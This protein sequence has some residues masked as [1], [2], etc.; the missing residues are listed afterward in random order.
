MHVGYS[1]HTFI[2]PKINFQFLNKIKLS[3]QR[4]HT[5]NIHVTFLSIFYLFSIVYYAAHGRGV[6]ICGRLFR[7]HVH[8]H[9][10]LFGL[11]HLFTLFYEEFD[12]TARVQHVLHT[13]GCS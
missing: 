13:T 9:K 11:L 7:I 1:I 10:E 6:Y 2:K 5:L 4:K 8:A 12:Y 3:V